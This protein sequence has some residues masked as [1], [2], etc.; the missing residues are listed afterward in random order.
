MKSVSRSVSFMA[1]TSSMLFPQRL[2]VLMYFFTVFREMY[3]RLAM[4]FVPFPA[5]YRS[6]CLIL[7]ILN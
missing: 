4:D 7:D 1:R 5:A 3:N 2:N 6:T